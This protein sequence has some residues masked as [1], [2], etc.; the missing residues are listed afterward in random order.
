MIIEKSK[1]P[2]LN[3]SKEEE[4][5]KDEKIDKILKDITLNRPRTPYAL[6]L[7]NEIESIKAKN[8]DQKIVLNEIAPI[9]LEKWHSLKEE[10]KKKYETLH[11]EDKYRYK[12]E[13]ELVRHYIF[14][15]SNFNSLNPIPTA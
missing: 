12:A 14:K 7:S 3:I 11:D 1:T 10:E 6:F 9:I 5:M 4:L 8:K 2:Y 13:I 15:D